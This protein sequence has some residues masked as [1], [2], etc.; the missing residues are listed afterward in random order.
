[1]SLVL[2]VEVKQAYQ[3][4][5]GVGID[6][7]SLLKAH[8]GTSLQIEHPTGDPASAV[9]GHSDKNQIPFSA[10]GPDDFEIGL[11]ER[12]ESVPEFRNRA[13]VSSVTPFCLPH[14]SNQ[15]HQSRVF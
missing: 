8:G 9:V 12:V 5:Q 10:D 15:C 7:R 3:S 14:T 13:K 4:Q 11:V 2:A 1:M 6:G